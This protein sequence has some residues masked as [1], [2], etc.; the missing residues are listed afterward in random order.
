MVIARGVVVAGLGLAC[1]IV[2]D[3]FALVPRPDA[4]R[5]SKVRDFM[6]C[7]SKLLLCRYAV[8]KSYELWT[9]TNDS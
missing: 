2:A 7:S 3:G 1:L 4:Y 8:P 5:V 6:V 9:L